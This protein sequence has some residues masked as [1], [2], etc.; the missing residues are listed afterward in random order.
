[1][2]MDGRLVIIREAGKTRKETRKRKRV[3]RTWWLVSALVPF[4]MAFLLGGTVLT[5]YAAAVGR[6]VLIVAPHPDDDILYG[7]GVAASA[8]AA[9]DAVKVVYVTNGDAAGQSLGETRQDEAVAAQTNNIGTTEDD[10]IF[11]GYPNEGL[12][13][14]FVDHPDESDRFTSVHGISETYADRG[15][16]RTDYHM[17]RF[18]S[19]APYNRASMLTD[20]QSL[21]SEYR[22]DDIY[23]TGVFDT[24]EE[25]RVTFWLVRTAVLRQMTLDAT[26][27]PALHVTMVHWPAVDWPQPADPTVA[28]SEPPGLSE[29]T[30]LAWTDRES[31]TVPSN[32]REPVLALN[33]KYLAVEA[34]ASQSGSSEYLRSFVHRDEIFWPLAVDPVPLTETNVGP[35]AALSASSENAAA[36]QLSSKAVDGVVDGYP[37]DSGREWA[38][39]GGSGN[40]LNMAWMQSFIVDRITLYDRPNLYDHVVEGRL[41]FSDGSHVQTGPL[42]NDGSA[43]V[44]AFAPRAIDSL[45]FVV[46]AV[47]E[48]TQAV[49][50]AEIEVYGSP[51]LRGSLTVADGATYTNSRVVGLQSAVEGAATMRFRD[52]PAGAWS[53][54]QPYAT[55]EQWQ[56]APGDGVRT[57]EAQFRDE[58][59]NVFATAD[60]IVLDTTAPRTRALSRASVRRGGYLTLRFSVLD[61]RPSAG[62]ATVIIKIKTLKGKTVKVMKL[63]RKINRPQRYRFLCELSRGTYRFHVHARDAAGNAQRSVA[64]SRLVVR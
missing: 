25:H 22:P 48:E 42:P 32:M 7:A 38:S 59:G 35:L 31:L 18:G 53:S 29:Q 39:G 28:M 17:Y 57:I 49:G 12:L 58:A 10:L 20:M 60:Q 9:G 56:M 6:T 15:L 30:D 13:A 46:E 2:R 45:R 61:R 36:G 44:I 24:H 63:E 23:T 64:R 62:R 55:Q 27:R 41:E 54:W 26:Y 21:L 51:E 37:G 34:H 3:S 19:H 52:G 1:M 47:G 4:A 8:V 5:G 11:L 43:H 50:L 40:W 16:G 14:T 33:A